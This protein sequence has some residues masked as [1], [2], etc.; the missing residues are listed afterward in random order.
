[1][2]NGDRLPFNGVPHIL[3]L[4]YVTVWLISLADFYLAASLYTTFVSTIISMNTYM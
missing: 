2:G 4:S 3:T 1:M